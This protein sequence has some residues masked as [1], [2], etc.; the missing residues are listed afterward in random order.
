MLDHVGWSFIPLY[1]LFRPLSMLF[2]LLIF[3]V[4]L[5]WLGITLVVRTVVIVR[6]QGCGV[7]VLAAL[8]GTLYQLIIIPIRW[9]DKTSEEMAS[10]VGKQMES[11]AKQSFL[12]PLKQLRNK[13][14]SDK[15]LWNLASGLF[16]KE[17]PNAPVE[18]KALRPV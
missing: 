9:A 10:N 7:R 6:A 16:R 12:Y 15:P 8:W 2:I 14:D 13:E 1:W 5:M 4:G 3:V 17:H 11:K 18:A